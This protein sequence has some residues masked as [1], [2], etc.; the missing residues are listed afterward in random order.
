MQQGG[1]AEAARRALRDPAVR[2]RRHRRRR[3]RR[4]AGQ[5][6]RVPAPLRSCRAWGPPD[7]DAPLFEG[8]ADDSLDFVQSSQRL[9]HMREP[10]V[11][12]DHWIKVQNPGGHPVVIVPDEDLHEQGVFPSTFNNDHKWT[13][14]IATFASWSPRSINVTDLMNG[15]SD[16]SWGGRER[17][18]GRLLPLRRHSADGSD[19]DAGG[20]VGDRDRRA[21]VD[22]RRSRAA[23]PHPARRYDVTVGTMP[24]TTERH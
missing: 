6:P 2:R 23:R 12:L 14:T 16:R 3:W 22:G 19:A 10:A 8:V 24:A 18:A 4:F 9:E 7:G 13:F 15:V 11:A 5:L 1:G 17:R 21:Q 20:R